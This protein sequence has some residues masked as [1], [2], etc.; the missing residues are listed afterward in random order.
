MRQRFHVHPGVVAVV[1][2]EQRV[3]FILQLLATD[4][5]WI[6]AA[7]TTTVQHIQ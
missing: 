1:S 2:N 5:G 4:D 7:L 3:G 6:L